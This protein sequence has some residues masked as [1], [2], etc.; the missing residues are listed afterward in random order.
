MVFFSVAGVVTAVSCVVAA[1]TYVAMLVADA[2]ER[3]LAETH[4]GD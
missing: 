2:S 3:H 4:R 1:Q